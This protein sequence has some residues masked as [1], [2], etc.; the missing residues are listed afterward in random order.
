MF[1]T[2]AKAVEWFETWLWP[3]GEMCCLLCGSTSAYRVKSGKPM[4]YRCRDC[5]RY[6]SIKSATALKDSKLP[7]KKWAWAIYLEMTSLKGVSSMKLHRDLGVTQKTAWFMLHRIREAFAEIATEFEGPVEVDETNVGGKR[8]NKPLSVRR[9][10]TGRGPVDMTKVI[11]M[12]DR[13]TNRV[14]VRVIDDGSAA[15]LHA[16]VNAH[17]Q[18]GAKVYT[19]DARGYIGLD[20]HESVNHTVGEYV[21]EMAHTNGIESFWSMLKRGYTG[22]YH[23][24]SVKH[25]E[26]YAVQFAGRHNVR[27]MDTVDQMQ[28][29]MA[30]L[31][32]RRLMYNDLIEKEAA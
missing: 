10:L 27:D 24:M 25:L 26:R 15:S 11:G 9:E 32:G 28:H 16:F 5:K 20:N 29:V 30:G 13:K 2:E 3:T 21:R 1:A 12:K 8:G 18:K 17:R 6:L 19:D 31:V 4:P 7:L 23:R 14:V 22:V